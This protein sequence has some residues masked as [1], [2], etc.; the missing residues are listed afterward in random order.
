MISTVIEGIEL[1][2]RGALLFEDGR[3]GLDKF[4][5]KHGIESRGMGLG[6]SE[7]EQRWYGW[8]HRAIFGFGVGDKIF[9][10]EFGD[11]KTHFAKHGTKPIKNM[12]DAK[13]A[14]KAFS[15]YVG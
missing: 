5:D 10:P 14:A 13:K 9:E 2:A 7:K 1:R 8:S 6:F 15:D 11:D 3:S 12:D 4:K